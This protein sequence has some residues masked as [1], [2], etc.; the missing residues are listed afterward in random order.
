MRVTKKL[1]ASACPAALLATL[2]IAPAFAQSTGS[3]QVETVVVTGTKVKLLGGLSSYTPVAKQNSAI[4]QSFIQTQTPGQTFFQNLNLLP[5][6]NFTN[7]DPYGVSG[8][9]IRMHGQDGNHVSVTLDGMPLNDT[10]NYAMYTNQMVDGEITEKVTLNQGSTDVDS[11]TAAVTGG[12]ISVRTQRPE[13]EFAAWAK[14]SGGTNAYQRYFTRIDSGEFGP[15]GTRAFVSGSYTTYDKFKGPGKLQKKQINA[16]IHQD[17]GDLGWINLAAH[18]NVNRNNSYNGPNITE[19]LVTNYGHW[20]TPGS[21]SGQQN[22]TAAT[23]T[24]ASIVAGRADLADNC[25]S[26]YKTKINPSDTGNI[27]MSS[28]WH[29]TSN[30]TLTTDASL[31]YVLANGGGNA[32]YI[33]HS[34]VMTGS[35]GLTPLPSTPASTSAF[36]CIKASNGGCDLNGDGDVLDTVRVYRANTTNTRRWGFNTS[37]IYR[38]TDDHTIRAAYTLDYGLHRQT[39]QA[40]LLKPDG[41]PYSVWGGLDDPEH[42]VKSADG[43]DIRN[44]D[45]KSKA[46]LNQASMDYEGDW[47]DGLLHTSLGFRLPFLERDLNQYCLQDVGSTYPT[48]TSEIPTSVAS[49]NTVFLPSKGTTPTSQK[50]VLPSSA[51]VRYNRFLPHIGLSSK[52]FGDQHYFFAAFTKE[53][54]A[55]RTDNLYANGGVDANHQYQA[56]SDTVPETSTN[57]TLGYK[58]FGDG[59]NASLSLWNSQV[60]NRLIS[61]YDQDAGV[62]TYHS[63]PGINFAGIDADV[64]YNPVDSLTLYASASYMNARLLADV[65]VNANKNPDGTYAESAYARTGGRLLSEVPNWTFTGRANYDVTEWMHVGVNGKYVGRRFATDTNTIRVPDYYKV[66]AD[67]TVDLDSLGMKGSTIQFNLDNIFDKHYYGNIGVQS[68]YKS[69]QSGCTSSPYVSPAALR[70]FSVTLSAKY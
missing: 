23:C 45:R 39:A 7:T 1:F 2:A 17:L 58:F 30:L 53:L 70:T 29:L 66:D 12:S 38:I 13:E 65:I 34:A 61:T 24:P 49:D 37:L 54:A 32:T 26:Y 20:T 11:P 41:S 50:Y 28:L 51:V 21:G 64:S 4:D 5:G 9:N 16:D 69:G 6:I 10:G 3:E 31:Q 67:L 36:G 40:A 47:G 43:V 63:V 19:N 59:V 14:V 57:Y 35:Y 8:G 27:R 68:C 42:R 52:P 56:F 22:E 25:G 48:C 60:K 55:P 15:W 44:R 62:S 33:E 18:F 46:I